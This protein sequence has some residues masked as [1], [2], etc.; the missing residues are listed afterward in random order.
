MPTRRWGR[1]TAGAIAPILPDHPGEVN[2]TGST[3]Q[4]LPACRL[5]EA[6]LVR[7]EL[8]VDARRLLDGERTEGRLWSFRAS[9]H[10]ERIRGAAWNLG[11][12]DVRPQGRWRRQ[13]A[14]RE[15]GDQP[16]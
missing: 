5:A 10:H 8:L 9:P 12:L 2:R 16:I 6:D 4:A 3:E 15:R 7:V 13:L 14:V 1:I 11:A